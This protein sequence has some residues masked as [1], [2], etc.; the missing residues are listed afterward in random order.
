MALDDLLPQTQEP[1]DVLSQK[2]LIGGTAI[3]NDI[4]VFTITVAKQFNKI[5]TARIVLLDGDAAAKEFALS[6]EDLF[7][8]GSEIEIQLGY[9]QLFQTVFKGVI[10]KHALKA[11][12]NSS[13]LYLEAKDKSVALTLR[14]KNNYFF[15]QKT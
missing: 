14:K 7:V 2:I 1:T 3:S 15:D 11:K 10:T 12:Q 5:A 9:H 4:G 13:F 6:N 8:P